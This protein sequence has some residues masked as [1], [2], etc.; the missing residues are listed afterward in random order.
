MSALPYIPH[1]VETPDVYSLGYARST[2]TT[3]TK[4]G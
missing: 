4:T 2:I 3:T 1:T